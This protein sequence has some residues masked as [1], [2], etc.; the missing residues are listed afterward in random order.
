MGSMLAVTGTD[1]E[2]E[3]WA[4]PPS[5]GCDEVLESALV[6]PLSVSLTAGYPDVVANGVL[7]LSGKVLGRASR[8]E[9]SFGDG[10]VFTNLSY[11]TSHSWTNPGDYNVTFTAYN[12]DNIGGVST[13][14]IVHVVPLASPQLTVG[15]LNGTNFSLTFPGQPGVTYVVEQTT[16]LVPPVLWQTVRTLMSTGAVMQ[17]TDTKATNTMRFYRTRVQ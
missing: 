2:G 15:G 13:N 14:L 7:L 8:L 5:I 6:G 1:F 11:L 12:A 10:P 3:P 16:N 9:W 17:V 4:S